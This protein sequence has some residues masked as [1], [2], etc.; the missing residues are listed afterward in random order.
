MKGIRD[1]IKKYLAGYLA[2]CQI[3][4][5]FVEGDQY[6]PYPP[7]SEEVEELI[8]YLQVK[9]RILSLWGPLLLSNT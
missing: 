6:S 7:T 4:N 3:H 1:F 2:E 5:P 9:V 8:L